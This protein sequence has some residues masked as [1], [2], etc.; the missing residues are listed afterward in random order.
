MMDM[1]VI[2]I[3]YWHSRSTEGGIEQKL[4]E[5]SKGICWKIMERKRSF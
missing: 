5:Y 3:M 4:L 2:S 1:R